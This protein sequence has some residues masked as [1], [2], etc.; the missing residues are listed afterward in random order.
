MVKKIIPYIAIIAV[1]LSMGFGVAKCADSG[2]QADLNKRANAVALD[3]SK[4]QVTI[5]NLQGQLTGLQADNKRLEQS[6]GILKQS[7]GRAVATGDRLADQ[8]DT[9]ITNVNAIADGLDGLDQ[10]IRV[11]QARS[12]IKD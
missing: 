6:I 11:V 2:I 1:C 5:G 7:S 3:L 8:I 10:I 4:S 9:S 12:S